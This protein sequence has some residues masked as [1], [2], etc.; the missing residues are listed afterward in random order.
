MTLGIL[1]RLAGYSLRDNQSYSSTKTLRTRLSWGA[2]VFGVSETE[3]ISPHI[4]P[5]FTFALETFRPGNG[6]GGFARVAG[7]AP[8][9]LRTRKW[10]LA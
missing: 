4:S 1:V 9:V 5:V 7:C 6:V 3:E 2:D 10:S 8:K